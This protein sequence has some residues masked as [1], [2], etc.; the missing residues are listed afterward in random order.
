MDR[1]SFLWTSGCVLAGAATL[2]TAKEIGFPQ[3]DKLRDAVIAAEKA[4][5][6]RLGVAVLDTASGARFA[7]RGDERFPMCSTFKLPLVATILYRADRG[8]VDL[9]RRIAVSKSDIVGWSPF[10]RAHLGTEASILEL[11]QAAISLS[12]NAAANLLLPVIG[13]P[14]GLTQTLRKFGDTV[15]RSDRNEPTMASATPGDPRDT[16][17]PRAMADLV[18]Q[19]LFSDLLKPGTRKQLEDWLLAS[20][21]G[22][23]RLRAGMPASWRIGHKTG[24]GPHGTANDVAVLYPP[25]R[26]PLIAACYLTQ[27]A[28]DDAKRD[29]VLAEVGRAIAASAG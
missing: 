11:C 16:T 5:G 28:G 10:A 23:S 19:F 24:T 9:Q 12:D 29:A 21:T 14:A 25:A 22:L 26:T 3:D 18:R 7:Y 4:S 27:G 6:G 20:E 17:S 1:R 8:E 15:T 2:A 13:D